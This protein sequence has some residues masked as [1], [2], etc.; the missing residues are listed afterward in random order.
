[1]LDSGV[2]HTHNSHMQKL[3]FSLR[4]GTASFLLSG[5][6]FRNLVVG[7]FNRKRLFY[8]EY[9][10]DRHIRDNFFADY[11]K[12][13]CVV[14]VGCA[15]PELLSMSQH[16]RES[17]WR[18]IGIEP[19]PDFVGLHRAAG[20]EVYQYAAADYSSDDQDF[21]VVESSSNYTDTNLS[22]HSYSS[23]KV[24]PEYENY[25]NGA[26]RYFNRRTIK[27]KVRP[28]DQILQENC[29]EVTT[30]NL[31]SVDVEGYELEVIKGFTPSRYGFPVI[32]LENLFHS[33]K[34][35]QFM[36][37]IG[38]KLHS[39]VRYNYVFVPTNNASSPQSK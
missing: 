17:G 19:N 36:T 23:L 26:V 14:E 12:K 35:A 8:A 37:A 21:E 10:T 7:V 22:A 30:I 11:S 2:Q 29:P 25:Y 39:K 16:F 18:C 9:F 3:A 20:N 15:T 24:K 6:R 31:L 5:L 28:L 34:Y 4:R 13:G 33:P 27:V 38:Y 1:M 32:V